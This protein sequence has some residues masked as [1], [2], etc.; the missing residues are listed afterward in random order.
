MRLS[1]P[2]SEA[3]QQAACSMLQVQHEGGLGTGARVW[4]QLGTLEKPQPLKA[5]GRALT[6]P[7]PGYLALEALQSYKSFEPDQT[8]PLQPR[9]FS[10]PCCEHVVGCHLPPP[11]RHSL[12][13][14][15]MKGLL[16]S[17]TSC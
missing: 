2:A 17:A 7:P 13:S 14:R 8:R 15:C 16:W 6:W 10:W 9:L 3:P 12:A 5:K 4:Q 1:V 11:F